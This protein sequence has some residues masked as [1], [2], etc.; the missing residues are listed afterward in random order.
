MGDTMKRLVPAVVLA[1]PFLHQPATAQG[2]APALDCRNGPQTELN[3]CAATDFRTADAK[4]NAAYQAITRRLADDPARRSLVEAQRAWIRLRD[5]ECAFDT[6]IYEGG[7]IRPMMFSECRR[8]MTEQRTADLN[9]Y[10]SCNQD[11]CTV[12]PGR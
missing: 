5:A 9:T 8:R 1:L 4:V 10:L 6:N 3:E 11:G 7:S 12:P 2:R